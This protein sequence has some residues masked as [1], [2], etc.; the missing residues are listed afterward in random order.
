MKKKSKV[1]Y[2][3]IVVVDDIDDR[4]N[5]LCLAPGDVVQYYD[6]LSP[7]PKF[8][9]DRV[10]SIEAHKRDEFIHI[11]IK[12]VGPMSHCNLYGGGQITRLYARVNQSDIVSLIKTV[13]H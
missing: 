7:K 8:V 9:I 1:T 12:Y 5:T 2:E 4:V 13:S 10:R 3:N 6:F 11:T